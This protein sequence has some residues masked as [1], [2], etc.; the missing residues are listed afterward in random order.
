MY[1]TILA[2][3]LL[4][5]SVLKSGGREAEQHDGTAEVI[6]AIED[7]AQRVDWASFSA[8]FSEPFV[9]AVAAAFDGGD[10]RILE[11]LAGIIESFKQGLTARDI[12]AEFLSNNPADNTTAG[13]R[14]AASRVTPGTS[15]RDTAETAGGDAAYRRTFARSRAL[16]NEFGSAATYVAYC[17]AQWSGQ[18]NLC[19]KT[20]KALTSRV[21]PAPLVASK[22]CVTGAELKQEWEA[23][24]PNAAGRSLQEE[25]GEFETFVAFRKHHKAG[26]VNIL[27]SRRK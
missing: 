20:R 22:T 21:P 9:E 24:R 14:L 25:F 8:A 26:H 2:A 6:A 10:A 5:Q 19:V 7:F 23:N 13:G 16:Q 18:V 4:R 1:M 11:E 17:R 3:R 15:T 12:Y 27:G